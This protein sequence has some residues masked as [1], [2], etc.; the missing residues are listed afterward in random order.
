M[1]DVL[2]LELYWDFFSS[3]EWS[4]YCVVIWNKNKVVFF[5]G[6]FL[7]RQNMEFPNRKLWLVELT[8]REVNVFFFSNYR[9]VSFF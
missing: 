7:F 6:A 8:K 1:M 2:E 5:L 3:M 9:G 4:K